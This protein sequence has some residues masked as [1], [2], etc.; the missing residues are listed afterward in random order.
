MTDPI[1]AVIDRL[2]RHFSTH[3]HNHEAWDPKYQRPTEGKNTVLKT[4]TTTTA[5]A[6]ATL[7]VL[8][9]CR[10][11]DVTAATASIE[12]PTT[13]D[14][15]E[16]LDQLATLQVAPEDTGAHYRREDWK[17]WSNQGGSCDTREI[18]L[19]EQGEH[20]TADGKIAGGATFDPKTCE[21]YAGH[22][23]SWRSLYDDVTVTDPAKL[24]VDH[25]VPLEEMAHSGTR[26]WTAA[27]REAYANDVAALIAVTARSNRQK[28][29]QDPATW[30]PSEPFRCE[31]AAWWVQI[32]VTW[33]QRTG[34][35]VTVDPAEH[36]ALAAVLSR[37]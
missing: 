15:R 28:G 34:H 9:G 4:A 11:G 6:L 14:Y 7:A 12:R 17:H 25:I 3:V 24:D 20:R 35:P 8:T 18:V 2:T 31:Y 19:N 36:D 10:P 23:N 16:Y 37:C 5:A 22:G 13:S 29:S 21:P 1:A 33:S 26:S 32:K 30:L 27:D